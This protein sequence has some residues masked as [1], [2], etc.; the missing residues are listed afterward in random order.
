MNDLSGTIPDAV[1]RLTS[2]QLF[3]ASFNALDLVTLPEYFGNFTFM[4]ALHLA[5]CGLTGTVPSFLSA[6]TLLSE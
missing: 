1:S 2:L 6:M 4:E 5:D 3:A